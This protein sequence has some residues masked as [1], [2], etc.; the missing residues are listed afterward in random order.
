MSLGGFENNLFA[1]NNK[2]GNNGGVYDGTAMY[3]TVRNG[4]QKEINFGG[5]E[6]TP[7][8]V[9]MVEEE[10]DN[11]D[12]YLIRQ[13]EFEEQQKLENEQKI[14]MLDTKLA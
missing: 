9:E 12:I 7:I 13:Q 8:S 1:M 11:N 2:Y 14:E 6:K 5:D 3:Q 4:D 10:G